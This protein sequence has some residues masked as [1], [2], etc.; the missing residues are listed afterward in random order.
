M[1]NMYQVVDTKARKVV[2]EGFEN[3]ESAR[4][5]RDE[6]NTVHKSGAEGGAKPRFVISR[7]TDHPHGATDGLDHSYKKKQWWN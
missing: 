4:I 2:A 7:G 3:R 5:V 1:V 6:H